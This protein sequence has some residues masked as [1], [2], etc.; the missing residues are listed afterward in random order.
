MF[1]DVGTMRQGALQQRRIGKGDPGLSRDLIQLYFHSSAN[2]GDAGNPAGLRSPRSTSS[3]PTSTGN[4]PILAVSGE[5]TSAFAPLQ[6]LGENRKEPPPAS[7]PSPREAALWASPPCNRLRHNGEWR[8]PS[9]VLREGS[10]DP[11]GGGG[12]EAP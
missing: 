9:G 11:Q 5:T 1:V 6:A 12:P 7:P 10:G 3:E 4:A 2:L 8:S